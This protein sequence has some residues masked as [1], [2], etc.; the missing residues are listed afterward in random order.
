MANPLYDYT[1]KNGVKLAG[2]LTQFSTDGTEWKSIQGIQSMIEIGNEAS[3]IDQTTIEDTAK[4]YIG[5]IK[6]GAD[7]SLEFVSYPD[8]ENQQALKDAA[9]ATQIVKFKHQWPSG[10]IATYEATLL[11]WKMTSG[12][13]EDL[14]KFSVSMKLNGDVVWSKAA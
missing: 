2:T 1:A 5:G 7:Q 13:V 4:R 3:T 14:M 9:N 11:G 6:D 10:E 12:G 8:D